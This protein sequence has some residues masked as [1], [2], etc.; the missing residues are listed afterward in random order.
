MVATVEVTPGATSPGASV[1]EVRLLE[2][3]CGAY[4]I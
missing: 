3:D 4:P 2:I 1:N